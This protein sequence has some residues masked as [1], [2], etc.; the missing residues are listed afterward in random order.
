MVRE[1]GTTTT[2]GGV[3]SHFPA[4][5]KKRFS[6]PEE[7]SLSI[8][9]IFLIN[10]LDTIWPS[11]AAA[12]YNAVGSGLAGEFDTRPR[13]G[14]PSPLWVGSACELLMN[15]YSIIDIITHIR[16]IGAGE[17]AARGADIRRLM[18]H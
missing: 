2:R 8:E 12:E 5:R 16:Y 3:R 11:L 17:A 4:G 13:D 6:A 9:N 7:P 18:G 10:A 14:P 1:I 15:S